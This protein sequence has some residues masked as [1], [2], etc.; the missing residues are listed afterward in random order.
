MFYK[1]W[2]LQE[3]VGAVGGGSPWNVATLTEILATIGYVPSGYP[4]DLRK[5]EVKELWQGFYARFYDYYAIKKS[6]EDINTIEAM[7]LEYGDIAKWLINFLNVLNNTYP[8][9]SKVLKLY[10]DNENKLLDMVAAYSLSKTG[11]NDTPQNSNTNGEYESE[12]Y[13]TTFQKSNGKTE[14]DL[15]TKMARLKEIQDDYKRVM[16]DWLLEFDCLV[17]FV[18]RG[19]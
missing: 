15:N 8:Y 17:I 12:D 9:Y 13:L 6:S 18:E 11:F 7:N 1:Y 4:V 2:T 19:V 5:D 16:N 3:M 10:K 14:S